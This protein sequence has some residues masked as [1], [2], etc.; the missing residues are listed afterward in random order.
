MPQNFDPFSILSKKKDRVITTDSKKELLS[1]LLSMENIFLQYNPSAKTAYFDIKNRVLTL[2]VWEKITNDLHDMLVVHEVGH[3]LD[4]PPDGWMEAPKAIAKRVYN[5]EK[6]HTRVIQQYMNVIE[7]VRIDKRQKRRY[8]GSRRNYLAGYQ[9][10]HDRGFFGKLNITPQ[11]PFIDRLNIYY[12]GGDLMMNIPFTAEEKKLVAAALETESWD[13]VVKL[14]EE[15]YRYAKDNPTLEDHHK[16]SSMN[17]N[18]GEEGDEDGDGDGYEYE[19]EVYEEDEDGN[20]TGEGEGKD[21]DGKEDGKD[22][23]GE[24]GDKPGAGSGKKLVKV[25]VKT[26]GKGKDGK[27]GEGKDKDDK[28]AKG[29]PDPAKNQ[30]GLAGG[31]LGGHGEMDMSDAAPTS[32]T[33]E[34]FD[35]AIAAQRK[36][37]APWVYLTTPDWHYEESIDDYPLVLAQQNKYHPGF[38][39]PVKTSIHKSLADWRVAEQQTISYMVKEF[40]MR[41]AA[42]IYART[43]IART[44][45]LDTNKLH[46]YRHSEDIFRRHAIVTDGK[47][48]GFVMV[49]DWSGSMQTNLKNTV[50]QLLSLVLFCRRVQ[51]PFEVYLFRDFNQEETQA[52]AQKYKMTNR[53]GGWSEEGNHVIGDTTLNSGKQNPLIMTNTKLRN[54]LS[55]R[56]N[57]ATLNNAMFNLWSMVSHG[58][59]LRCDN[60][61]GTPLNQSIFLLDKVVEKFK[62][63]NK[64][65]IV[66][67]IIMTDGEAS[68][69]AMY[70]ND[71]SGLTAT[72]QVAGKV[73]LTD[74]K[75]RHSYDFE[76]RNHNETKVMLDIL[77]SRVGGNLIG[78]YLCG[79][80][81]KNNA[82]SRMGVAQTEEMQ[83]T[84]KKENF[85]SVKQFG[86]DAYFLVKLDE[87]IH[88]QKQDLQVDKTTNSREAARK[89]QDFAE[90]KLVNRVLLR[91]FIDI[92]AKENKHKIGQKVS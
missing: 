40:E 33:Q 38:S 76:A 19:I 5:D 43:S 13:E 31:D 37:G 88:R 11:M 25:K 10:I 20:E 6:K 71:K 79:D 8:P 85:V 80:G 73:V 44:G 52:Y 30:K 22:G 47:N 78:I 24:K 87:T 77:K 72:N 90:K 9:E 41:K 51:I 2:P 89:F 75:T 60:M 58:G 61:T 17:F 46:S 49:I 53:Y 86:Y 14:T 48:H 45:V 39:D 55:S 12:K 83:N 62:K 35:A 54:I 63:H 92:I 66:S 74:D 36:S 69:G 34:A 59:V 56:M 32:K 67:T 57:S 84:W 50:Q 81:E 28:N 27:D 68:Y 91:Q 3:A 7:D 16:F 29:K 1:R 21:K 82:I 4:T 64:V 23:K 18:E 26:K 70:R 42:D 15:V 65:Q